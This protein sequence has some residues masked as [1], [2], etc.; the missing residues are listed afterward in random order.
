[1]TR[2]HI[3]RH[4]ETEWNVKGK[5]QGH[6]DSPLTQLGKTQAHKVKSSIT[7]QIDVAY[8]SPSNRTIETAQIILNGTNQPIKTIPELKE[9]NLG[10]WEGKQKKEVETKYP[11][12]YKTF[13][14]CPS[15]FSLDQAETFEDLQERAIKAVL[16][17]LKIEDGKTVL[18]VSHHTPIKVILSYFENRPIDKIWDPPFVGNGSHSIVEKACD[19]QIKIVSYSGLLEW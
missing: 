10:V 9:I 15:K 18:L 13:W 11:T 16:K 14:S 8:S 17:I 12:E 19:G 3:V 5:W 4:G 6:K 7:E 2:I 1:M